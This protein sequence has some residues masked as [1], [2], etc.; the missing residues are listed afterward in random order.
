MHYTDVKDNYISIRF[1]LARQSKIEYEN[2]LI[3]LYL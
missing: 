3:N 2:D 1:D